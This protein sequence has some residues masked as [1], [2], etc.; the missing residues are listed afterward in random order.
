M[1]RRTA[2]DT[3]TLYTNMLEALQRRLPWYPTDRV[4]TRLLVCSFCLRVEPKER[5][6]RA[7]CV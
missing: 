1:I 4:W 3:L 6:A 7:N 2:P 5:F